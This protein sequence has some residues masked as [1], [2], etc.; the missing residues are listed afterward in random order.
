MLSLYKLFAKQS[1]IQVLEASILATEYFAFFYVNNG[2]RVLA[3]IMSM[4]L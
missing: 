1:F 3:V 4:N 2:T